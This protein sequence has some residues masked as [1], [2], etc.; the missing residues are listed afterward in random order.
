MTDQ[1]DV[2]R[3]LDAFFVEG[4]NEVSD[5]VIDAALDQIDH[6]PQRRAVRTPWR[7]STMNTF[8]RIAAAAAIGALAVGG[9]LYLLR[10]DQGPAATPP[11]A[12][13]PT[14]GAVVTP[15]PSQ[16]ITTPLPTGD[17]CLTFDIVTGDAL[18]HIEGDP[19]TAIGSARGV[20]LAGSTLFAAGP[21]PARPIAQVTP[22]N[23]G[24][25]E[26]LDLSADGSMALI[27]AGY[28][29]GGSTDPMCADILTVRIDGSGVTRLTSLERERAVVGA[30]FSPDG[31]RVAYASSF[32]MDRSDPAGTLTV[33]DLASGRIVDQPCALTSIGDPRQI[34]WSPTGD[35]IALAC[36]VLTTFDAT[37]VAAPREDP[38]VGDAWA[39]HWTD[40]AHLVV[41]DQGGSIRTVDVA[42]Q[43]SRIIGSVDESNAEFA[44]GS[45]VFSPDGLWLAYVG[46]HEDGSSAGYVAS[47]TGGAPIAVLGESDTFAAWSADS[48]ALIYT[49]EGTL[50]RVDVGSLE[51]STI[52]AIAEYSMGVRYRQG[53]WRIP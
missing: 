39:F 48:R 22:S 1:R 9:S 23:G 17:P 21:G 26:V 6:T 2:D 14:T 28:V 45:G 46:F 7:L 30:A 52:A 32:R 25:I 19:S 27:R 5:R 38:I 50:A 31:T 24:S 34:E 51:R 47:A 33:H 49:T 20:F 44:L 42:S 11:P 13:S 15:S 10:P 41:V 18:A 4:T 16:P 35:M 8:S 40:A 43:T 53:I 36:R 12:V 29:G 3:L 37:G